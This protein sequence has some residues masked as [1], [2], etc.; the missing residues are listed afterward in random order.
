MPAPGAPPRSPQEFVSFSEEMGLAEELD[1]AVLEEATAT[2]AHVPGT[3][4]AVN[5]SGVSMQKS[6]IPGADA[7]DRRIRILD[8]SWWS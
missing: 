1:L 8:A 6:G 5:V 4:I 2:L 3:A 7:G